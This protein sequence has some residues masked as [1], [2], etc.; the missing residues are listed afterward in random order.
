M[1]CNQYVTRIGM[2]PEKNPIKKYRF[3]LLPESKSIIIGSK[4]G[5]QL[6]PKR[7]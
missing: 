3:L 1:P 4:P 6:P 7:D 5:R 2:V